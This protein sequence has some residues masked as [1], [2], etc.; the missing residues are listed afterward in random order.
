VLA[1]TGK[2]MSLEDAREEAYAQAEKIRMG[3]ALFPEDIGV[4]L[5]N[6]KGI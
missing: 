5:L 4:D 1:V 2:G 3:R 6:Y